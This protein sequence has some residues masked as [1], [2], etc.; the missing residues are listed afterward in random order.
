MERNR[1]F[2]K[3]YPK[4]SNILKNIREEIKNDNLLSEDRS[5][6]ILTTWEKGKL[7]G[8]LTI[9]DYVNNRAG[10][11]RADLKKRIQNYKLKAISSYNFG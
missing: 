6:Q 1:N 4:S 8:G 5:F 9:V 7:S 3:E 10:T 2:T 11:G